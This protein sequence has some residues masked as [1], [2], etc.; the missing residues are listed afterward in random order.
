MAALDMFA[1]D[2]SRYMHHACA[3]AWPMLVEKCFAKMCGSYYKMRGGLP[4]EAFSTLTG[5]P[6]RVG[7]LDCTHLQMHVNVASFVPTLYS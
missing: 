6:V 4:I 2:V 3:E 7:S 5:C 1:V